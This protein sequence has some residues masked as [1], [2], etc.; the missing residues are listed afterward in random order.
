MQREFWLWLMSFKY[1]ILLKGFSRGVSAS[2]MTSYT[3]PGRNPLGMGPP[4]ANPWRY[5]SHPFLLDMADR[6]QHS[7]QWPLGD[8]SYR[9]LGVYFLEFCLKFRSKFS[10]FSTS[11]E[12]KFW[13][14][15]C[16]EKE[17]PLSI[18]RYFNLIA[19]PHRFP[20]QSRRLPFALASDSWQWFCFC[21]FTIQKH[22][23]PLH[24]SICSCVPLLENTK[25]NE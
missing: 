14:F 25:I 6:D 8:P 17:T 11:E 20:N 16:F 9:F 10:F 18:F 13:D 7:V 2:R 15:E 5:S 23:F 3:N 12:K 24:L 22:H 19:E 4:S 21:F 1:R